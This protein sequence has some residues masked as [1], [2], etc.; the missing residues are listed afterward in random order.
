MK[1][2]NIE[3]KPWKPGDRVG[4]K[5]FQDGQPTLANP[6]PTM[7]LGYEKKVVKPRRKVERKPQIPHIP[8][9]LNHK[10]DCD[11]SVHDL[12]FHEDENIETTK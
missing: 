7:V 8:K 6:L 4:Y 9:T 1:R 2:D 12:I 5:H 3:G 11:V 10:Q